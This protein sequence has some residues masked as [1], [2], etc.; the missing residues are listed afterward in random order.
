MPNKP[1]NHTG[2]DNAIRNSLLNNP[3]EAKVTW[4]DIYS[5]LPKKSTVVKGPL[6]DL[7][8]SLNSFAGVA[9][10]G[11]FTKL[12]SALLVVKKN[13]LALYIAVG[14]IIIGTGSFIT[15]NLLSKNTPASSINTVAPAQEAIV[16][17]ETPAVQQGPPAINNN[18]SV[19]IQKIAEPSIANNNGPINNVS[20]GT[21]VSENPN[22][23]GEPLLKTSLQYEKAPSANEPIQLKTGE[24]SQND[25]YDFSSNEDAVK[26]DSASEDGENKKGKV[27]YYKESLTLDKLE[28]QIST[29]KEQQQI[30]TT[31]DKGGLFKKRKRST[32]T[33]K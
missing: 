6:A 33:I 3:S 22:L 17:E 28:Q 21:Q 8:F 10:T 4:E 31:E 9:A 23:N 24:P 25:T 12:K 16:Q 20:S 11:S 29:D 30:N 19:S 5:I 26:A 27:L 14:S 2:L 1:V 13:S 18:T 7:S 15:Y 32:N